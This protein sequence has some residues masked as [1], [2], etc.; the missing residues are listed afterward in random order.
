MTGFF[1]ADQR[2]ARIRL[3]VH[4]AAGILH[5]LEAVVDTGFT[6]ELTLDAALIDALQLPYLLTEQTMLSDGSIVP[7]A[8]HAATVLWDGQERE[9]L[10]PAGVGLL[11]G[12]ELRLQVAR[13]GELRLTKIEDI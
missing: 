6:E 3:F 2:E 11:L 4:G 10:V 5:E 12:Y 7:C 1:D 9:I 13:N 8:V